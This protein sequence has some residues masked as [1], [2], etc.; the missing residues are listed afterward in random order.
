SIGAKNMLKSAAK[1]REFEKQQLQSLIKEKMIELDRL[2]VEYESL[3]KTE[4]EQSEKMEQLSLKAYMFI[5]INLLFLLFTQ[6][7]QCQ[8]LAVNSIDTNNGTCSCNLNNGSCDVSCCCDTDCSTEDIKAFNC[9]QVITNEVTISIPVKPTTQSTCFKNVPI[10][11]SNSPYIIEKQGDIVCVNH[12]QDDNAN[13]AYYQQQ[14]NQKLDSTTFSRSINVDNSVSSPLGTPIELT[15]Y[16][17]GTSIFRYIPTSN[18]SSYYSLPISLFNSQTCSGLQPIT[19]M[20]DFTST[21]AQPVNE[22]TCLD[23]LSAT[24]YINSFCLITNPA[25]LTSNNRSYVCCS[26]S[27]TAVTDWTNPTCSNALRT[28]TMIIYY[29]N[30]TGITNCSIILNTTTA[31]SGNTVPQTFTIRFIQNG[32]TETKTSRSGN[33]G[34]LQGFPIIAGTSN[35]SY[36]T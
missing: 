11:K 25:T 10:Y 17:A 19:Y 12:D 20:N 28:L 18:I 29:L 21:C 27:S 2:R 24:K 8:N 5:L 22:Q 34:Y 32:L 26:A 36:I 14:I 1:Y 4:R 3:Q 9:N 13:A 6:L 23:G 30:P 33:P 7:V 15:S 31:T 35:G 16:Q